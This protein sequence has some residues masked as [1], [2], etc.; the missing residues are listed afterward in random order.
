M[1]ASQGTGFS[2]RLGEALRRVV[3]GGRSYVVLAYAFAG[4]ATSVYSVRADGVTSYKAAYGVSYTGEILP[5]GAT[6]LFK[7]PESHTR[8]VSST[9][10]RSKGDSASV[11]GTVGW[12]A[13]RERRPHLPHSK[14]VAQGENMSPT[15]APSTLER[16]TLEV[17][18]GSSLGGKERR[19][20]WTSTR[21]SR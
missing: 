3:D 11:K 13:Q 1:V 6:A 12:R 19:D 9:M 17:H 15:G 10:T 18:Q 7:V 2:L 21:I 5:F 4:W 20:R 8:Q 14:R 16:A